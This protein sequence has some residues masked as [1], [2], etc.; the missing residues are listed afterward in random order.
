MFAYVVDGANG[1]VIQ[2][3]RGTGFALEALERSRIAR[4]VRGKKF[5]GNLTAE[6]RI[7]CAEYLAHA[8]AAQ[9]VKNAVMRDCFADHSN[10]CAFLFAR[11][12]KQLHAR[13]QGCKSDRLGPWRRK[14]KERQPARTGRE[15]LIQPITCATFP[16]GLGFTPQQ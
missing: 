5:K 13:A 3:R 15:A 10:F 14:W 7:F 8:A 2:G 12:R 9:R 16:N 6:A 1:R 4:E 11:H